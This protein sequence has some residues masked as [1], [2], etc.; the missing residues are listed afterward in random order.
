MKKYIKALAK[1]RLTSRSKNH[2]NVGSHF[3]TEARC[4]SGY[5]LEI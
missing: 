2:R 5:R 4:Y 1:R 3:R